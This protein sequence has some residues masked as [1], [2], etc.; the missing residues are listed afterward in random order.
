MFGFLIKKTFFDMWD[1]MISI[2]LMNLGFIAC[3]A[4]VVYLP[5]LLSFNTVLAYAGL[6]LGLYAF[7]I[8]AGAV[9]MMV[10]DIAD[11]KRCE[12]KDFLPSLRS[13]FGCS[14]VLTLI[15]CVQLL[16]ALVGFPFYSQMGG[17]FGLLALSVLFWISLV[18]WLGLQYFFPVRK[19]L[20]KNMKK[21]LKK[22]FIIFFDN[23]G[24][25]IG[26]ALGSL[27]IVAVSVFTALLL[28]GIATLFLWQQVAA[29]LRLLKYDYLEQN[30]DANRKRIPWSALL[31]EEREKVGPR[32]L[33]GMIFPWK[34]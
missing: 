17:I 28:P 9:S 6:A 12:F 27:V 34:E 10:G 21:I 2:V 32:T 24:F 15:T 30:P 26:L 3:I 13:A 1:N 20:D 11:Y 22:S 16:V 18:L 4:L 19:R 7:N 14:S 33:K 5:Y 31:V 8:Y 25:S 29:K 23:T